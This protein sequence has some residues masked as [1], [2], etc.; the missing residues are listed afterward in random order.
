MLCAL[1]K[2]LCLLSPPVLVTAS[3]LM[4]DLTFACLVALGLHV[5]TRAMDEGGGRRAG[6]AGLLLGL[7]T[8]TRP[9]GKLL[10]V[11]LVAAWWVASR[12]RKQRGGRRFD[13][14][15]ATVFLIASMALPL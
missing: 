1:G 2:L 3:H 5:A 10:P 12:S 14:K 8:V 13:S 9:V 7:A 4:S 11:I 6:G 15:V